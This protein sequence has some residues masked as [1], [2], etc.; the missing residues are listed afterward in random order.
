[1]SQQLLMSFD[2]V[3]HTK[4][5][6]K[7]CTY[8][9]NGK[10]L[11][12]LESYLY[13]RQQCVKIGNT[14]SYLLPVLSGVHQGSILGPLLFL[15]YINDLPDCLASSTVYMF[16]DDSKCMHIIRNSNHIINFQD[17]LNSVYLW[18]QTWNLTSAKQLLL[19]LAIIPLVPPTTFLIV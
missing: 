15:M 3:P 10:L 13:D 1:M 4:L 17:D 2:S 11:K 16:A 7:L 14:T 6:H 12:W 8:G 9:I 19:S 18:S 5:L